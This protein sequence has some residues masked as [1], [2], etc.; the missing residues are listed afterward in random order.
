MKKKI[1]LITLFLLV[2]IVTMFFLLS[3]KEKSR[4]K[5]EIISLKSAVEHKNADAALQYISTDYQDIHQND[6][7]SFTYSIRRL[8]DDFD[9]IKIVM[10]GIKIKVDSVNSSNTVFAECSMGLKIFA[11]YQ[12]D[13]TLVYGGVIKPS[14]VK[15][16]LKRS[17]ETYQIYKAWY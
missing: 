9:S 5:R 8:I 16:F 2:F 11:R 17:G 14:P 4:I 15:A 12:G 13:R 1:I 3:P 7:E 10:T 6:Y